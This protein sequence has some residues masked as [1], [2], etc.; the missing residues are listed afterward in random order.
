ME[1]R[2]KEKKEFSKKLAFYRRGTVMQG[3]AGL[4]AALDWIS[5]A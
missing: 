4:L 1:M 3:W 5:V 2:E